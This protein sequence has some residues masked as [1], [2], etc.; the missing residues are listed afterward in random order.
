MVGEGCREKAY[1]W[2]LNR[3]KFRFLCYEQFLHKRCS[4]GLCV[5][6][7]FYKFQFLWYK[8]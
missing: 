4:M 2:S 1:I 8:T 6:C 5:H 7:W 3:G